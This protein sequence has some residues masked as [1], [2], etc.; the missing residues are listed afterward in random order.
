MINKSATNRRPG[1]PK[2][3]E[4]HEAIR[5]AGAELFLAVGWAGT[6]MDAIA[7]KAGVS[8]QTVYSHFRSKEDLFRECIQSKISL[9][10]LDADDRGESLE[11]A[12]LRYGRRF[13]E[14]L[15]DADVVRMYRLMIAHAEEFPNLVRSFQ[16]AGPDT[17]ER[18]FAE[19]L[20]KVLPH[21]SGID[22]QDAACDYLQPIFV[23]VLMQRLMNQE[24]DV[25]DGDVH[26]YLERNVH[27]F[28][29][30]HGLAAN[31]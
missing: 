16:E 14:L 30:I 21:D 19:L 23:D 10:E 1:R 3:E 20:A 28:L 5:K 13:Y 29:R 26:A 12:L 6:S 27:R 17:T 31:E 15:N 11:Q 22:P 4:K 18:A 8:K 25:P 24:P 2:S 7:Q 9:Y